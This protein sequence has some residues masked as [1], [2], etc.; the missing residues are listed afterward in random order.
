MRF[1]L[2]SYFRV[3][4]AT[5]I[6][7]FA[8]II[9][10]KANYGIIDDHT[11]T[12]TLLVKKHI[13][14]FIMPN[15]G[16]FY[17]ALAIDFN[18]L[19]YISNDASFFY[20]YI[21]LLFI[22]FN[23]FLHKTLKLLS[24][25]LSFPNYISFLIPIFIL[26]TP[27]YITI[28]LRLF[29]CERYMLLLGIIALFVYLKDKEVYTIKWKILASASS[30]IFLF[31]KEPA[32]I[33]LGTFGFVNLISGLLK[34]EKINYLDAYFFVISLI[35]A[36]FYY[37]LIYKNIADGT[38]GK[39]NESV[40]FGLLRNVL[41]YAQSDPF[42]IILL[43]FLTTYR[44]INIVLNYSLKKI[45]TISIYDACL[46]SS[47]AY[48]FFYLTIGI[49]FGFHYL[50]PAYVFFLPA[51][52]YF[53]YQLQILKIKLIKISFIF[54]II[55]QIFFALPLSLHLISFYK[56]TPN[57][58]H[59]TLSFLREYLPH[60][61]KANQNK[62]KL[63]LIGANKNTQVETYISFIDWLNFYGIDERY[64]DLSSNLPDNKIWNVGK[65]GAPYIYHSVFSKENPDSIKTGDIGIIQP[66]SSYGSCDINHNNKIKILF[67]SKSV[68]P[69]I[70]N[71]SLEFSKF[72]GKI[73]LPENLF[74]QILF[75]IVNRNQMKF[76]VF[77]KIDD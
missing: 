54:S 70:Q 66:Y 19:S 17:P 26:T 72:I 14:F 65:R 45:E 48:V 31:Y 11:L 57:N 8:L 16:R 43:P 64:Y 73:L 77:E 60:N 62:T 58:F 46:F 69:E 36:I 35:Y 28:W 37:L 9:T 5:V 63:F 39:T 71:Y 21:A 76:I 67:E 41:A 61:F 2:G 27:S 74:K 55:V 49:R 4:S 44:L 6:I 40:F 33:I 32:F 12:K 53:I 30:L 75:N 13:P 42:L 1:N 15:I 29:M 38:Y 10:Y 18:L 68:F 34:K 22:I 47:F 23:F 52:L 20:G 25:K 3:L 24:D 7:F 50:T 59:Q 51:L 56:N